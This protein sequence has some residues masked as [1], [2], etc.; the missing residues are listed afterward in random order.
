VILTSNAAYLGEHKTY[1]SSEHAINSLIQK[2]DT[3]RQRALL[4]DEF[5]DYAPFRKKDVRP[6]FMAEYIG[7]NAAK[8]VQALC[9]AR[10]VRLFKRSGP[11]MMPVI[12]KRCSR[13]V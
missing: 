7:A 12:S 11:N 9:N 5:P 2:V 8:D 3:V 1:L 4:P 13:F 6:F 10:G